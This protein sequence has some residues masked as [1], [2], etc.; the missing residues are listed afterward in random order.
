MKSAGKYREDRNRNFE[1]MNDFM[2]ERKSLVALLVRL[3]AKSSRFVLDADADSDA[4]L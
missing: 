1:Y 2:K 3:R 4:A